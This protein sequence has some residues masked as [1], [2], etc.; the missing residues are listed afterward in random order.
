MFVGT[1]IGEGIG[2]GIDVGVTWTLLA[3]VSV[4]VGI[5]D[6]VGV[7]VGVGVAVVS[8]WVQATKS[9]PIS[10][11]KNGHRMPLSMP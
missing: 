5:S 11:K 1:V 7:T 2:V 8:G 3:G 10:A 4:K 6:C 9:N